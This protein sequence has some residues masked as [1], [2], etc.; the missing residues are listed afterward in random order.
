MSCLATE[1]DPMSAQFFCCC[2]FA[3]V[4]VKGGWSFDVISQQSVVDVYA[5][6]TSALCYPKTRRGQVCCLCSN[7]IIGSCK[8]MFDVLLQGVSC[9]VMKYPIAAVPDFRV[10]SVISF[11]SARK[12]RSMF[13]NK[14]NYSLHWGWKWRMC[15]TVF[16]YCDAASFTSAK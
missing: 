14:L 9:P 5:F 4:N 3:D 6:C 15:V 16:Q 13:R 1:T 10:V 12:Q 11:N 2:F 7:V 8:I